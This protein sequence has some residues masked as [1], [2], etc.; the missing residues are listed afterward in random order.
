[1]LT[2]AF[3]KVGETKSEVMRTVCPGAASHGGSGILQ[4]RDNGCN[5]HDATQT[6]QTEEDAARSINVTRHRKRTSG[7]D[8][9][10][11]N[12]RRINASHTGARQSRPQPSVLFSMNLNMEDNARVPVKN[13]DRLFS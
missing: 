9:L 5:R 10:A 2:K 8:V 13:Q 1:M 3:Q 4:C 7:P 11:G 12:G 6:R